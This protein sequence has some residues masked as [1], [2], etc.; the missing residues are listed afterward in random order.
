MILWFRTVQQHYRLTEAQ[1]HLERDHRPPQSRRHVVV[2]PIG[3]VNQPVL[4]ALDYARNQSTEVYAVH[5]GMEKEHTA[6]IQTQWAQWSCGMPLIVIPL[7]DRSL[8]R[9]LVLYIEQLL[10]TD[11]DAWVT[12]VLPEILP[13]RWW[14]TML[15]NRRPFLLKA[16]L[17]FKQRVIFTD[18]PFHLHR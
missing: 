12:V 1:V 13:V 9:S 5:V 6:R 10:D 4:R 3:D 8:I 14:Q 11:T 16:A 7:T 15:H 17:L 2:V 18:V